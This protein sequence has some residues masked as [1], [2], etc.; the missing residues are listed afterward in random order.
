MNGRT[1]GVGIMLAG[2]VLSGSR[3]D[4]AQIDRPNLVVRVYMTSPAGSGEWKAT[5]REATA[6]LDDAGVDLDWIS[7]PAS[8]AAI[9]TVPARCG[10]PLKS[11]EVTVRI[12]R[13]RALVYRGELPLGESLLDPARRIGT[14][15]TIYADRV[16]WLA[17]SGGVSSST[18]L[19]RAI[20][21]EIGHLLL[22]TT[23]H[24][25]RG[26][27]RTVWSREELMRARAVDW[28]FPAEDAARLQEAF[29][30]RLTAPPESVIVW[31]TH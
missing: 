2:A 12:I 13:A 20:A 15:A 28:L 21:H 29:A 30:R 7:C 5:I 26:L 4:A 11:N 6:I 9:D 19:A 1:L 14:L 23:A 3:V 31:S 27:M 18:V 10:Q 25:R 8:A 24:S 22:G 16:E 17:R